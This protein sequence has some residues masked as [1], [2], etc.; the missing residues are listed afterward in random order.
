MEFPVPISVSPQLFLYHLYTAFVPRE[1]P[2]CVS[3][4]ELPGQ[5]VAE[6]D[7]I[8]DAGAVDGVLAVR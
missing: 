4:I 3:R 8:I 6:G 1:P 5:V 2:D 7:G